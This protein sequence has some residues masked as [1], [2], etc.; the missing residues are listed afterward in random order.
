MR[1]KLAAAAFIGI[2]M[3]AVWPSSSEAL[4]NF[5]VKI[6]GTS[7]SIPPGA[8]QVDIT[9]NYGCFTIA[10]LGG[11]P[12]LVKANE[13]AQDEILLENAFFTT[14]APTCNGDVEFFATF[15][16]PPVASTVNVTFERYAGIGALKRGGSGAANSWFKVTGWVKDGGG[17]DNEINIWKKKTATAS[18]FTFDFTNSEDWVPVSLQGARD[19]RVQFWFFLQDLAGAPP[20]DT[21]ELPLARVKSAGGGG[22]KNDPTI[23]NDPTIEDG[24]EECTNKCARKSE[25]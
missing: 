3:A 11:K 6:N 21:L 14:T 17:A 15:S 4:T 1:I 8:I 12:P 2:V 16:N 23:A 25:K 10:G 7:V 13:G 9:G 5:T 20:A 18:S 24:Y 19:L 22:G